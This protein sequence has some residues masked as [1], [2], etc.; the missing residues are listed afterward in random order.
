MRLVR[1]IDLPGEDED[2]GRSWHWFERPADADTDGSRSNPQPVRWQVHTDD[3]TRNAAACVERLPLPAELKEAILLAAR[4]HDLGKRRQLFQTILGN[5][6]YPAIEL[7]KSGPRGGRVAER[8]RHEFGSLVDVLDEQQP[9]RA[10]LD[11]LHP[12]LQDVV[13]HLIAA[14]HGYGRPHFPA[15]CAFDP[16]PKGQSA[17]AIAAAVVR[18]F[19]RLQRRYGR[20]GLAYLESLLRAADY[21]A[22]AHPSAYLEDEA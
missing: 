1:R 21:A 19:A 10:E 13:L 5:Y 3:V 17:E 9:Y 16:E 7:A 15:D 6:R 2:E 12:D 18:R 4:W 22:S 8:Y 20:W 11:R 14:H